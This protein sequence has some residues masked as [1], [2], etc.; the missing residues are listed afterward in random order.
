MATLLER[1]G[2]G[3]ATGS[4]KWWWTDDSCVGFLPCRCSIVFVPHRE[5]WLAPGPVRMWPW[6]RRWA[7]FGPSL[8]IVCVSRKS[9]E[10]WVR[11]PGKGNGYNPTRGDEACH[12]RGTSGPGLIWGHLISGLQPSVSL[13]VLTCGLR[14]RLIYCAPLA[15]V[16]WAS[17]RHGQ[18][19]GSDA[20]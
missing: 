5:A 3:G 13:P 20:R 14:P 15:L 6:T 11:L 7:L 9:V 18:R 10:K 2:S 12:E 19:E 8:I 1:S 17:P 16:A 4:A